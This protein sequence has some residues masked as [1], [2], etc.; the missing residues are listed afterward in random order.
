MTLPLGLII[1]ILLTHWV[2]DYVLQSDSLALRKSTSLS[3]LI[4]HSAIYTSVWAGLLIFLELI[5]GL[6]MIP[7]VMKFCAITFTT[8][9]AIDY[10]TSRVQKRLYEQEKRR[11]FFISLGFDQVLHLIQLFAC[12]TLLK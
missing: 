12:F 10:Y 6:P 2:A 4:T 9:A 3:A 11:E 5:S 1:L 8:H 7:F